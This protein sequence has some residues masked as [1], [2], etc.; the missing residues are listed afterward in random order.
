MDEWTRSLDEWT[1]SICGKAG[2][3]HCTWDEEVATYRCH[4]CLDEYLF[5]SQEG[6]YDQPKRD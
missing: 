1:C 4:E 3:Y 5:L 6:E 2:A